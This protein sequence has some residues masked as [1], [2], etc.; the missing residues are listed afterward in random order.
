MV[1]GLLCRQLG[2]EALL[3]IKPR[4]SAHASP[5]DAGSDHAG[6]NDAEPNASADDP[7]ADDP[8]A[9]AIP[10]SPNAVL[11]KLLELV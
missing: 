7:S 11:G 8:I 6:P 1:L 3:R 2:L 5:N 10:A 4:T 9:H